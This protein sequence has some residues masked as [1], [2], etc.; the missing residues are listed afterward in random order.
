MAIFREFGKSTPGYLNI[1]YEILIKFHRDRLRNWR[2][3][4]G[5]PD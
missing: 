3:P 1:M 4:G 2:K 5:D